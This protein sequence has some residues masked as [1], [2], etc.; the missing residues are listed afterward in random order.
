MIWVQ[1]KHQRPRTRMTALSS[2]KIR[3]DGWKK[4]E[5]ADQTCLYHDDGVD[6]DHCAKLF[7]QGPAG[8]ANIE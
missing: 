6:V 4:L 1:H 2:H 7:E 8:G 5:Y 3:S